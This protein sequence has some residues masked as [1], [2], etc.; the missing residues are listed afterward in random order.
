MPN[1]K[2]VVGGTYERILLAGRTGSGKSSQI[3]TLPGRKFA[4]I[5]DP[6]SLSSLQGCDLDYE[7]FMPDVLD[8]DMTLKGFNKNPATQKTYVGDKPKRKVEPVVFNKWA[9]H[10]NG[11]YDKG[12][13]DNYDWLIFDSITFFEKSVMDRNLFINNRYG[14]IEDIADYRIVGSKISEIFGTITA[15]RINIYATG[16][17]SQ[18]QDE[19]TK[20]LSIELK[21]AGKAKTMLPLQFSNIWLARVGE[22]EKGERRYEIRTIPEPRGFQDVRSS[23]RGL[24]PDEDVT[25]KDFAKAKDYGIGKLLM[26]KAKP[27]LKAA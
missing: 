13:F 18:F 3:W 23:I 27:A 2:D 25:I 19:K 21:V 12:F 1:A 24:K 7:L 9:D 14:D 4:Y 10:F 26:T 20:K 17:L 8:V 22:D 16:H 5:F 15:M 6:N 11:Q